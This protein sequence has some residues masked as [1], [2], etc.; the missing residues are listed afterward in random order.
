MNPTPITSFICSAAS[1]RSPASRSE[2]S[3]GSMKWTCAPNVV[4]G[5]LAAAVRAVVEGLV[6]ASADVED[7]ADVE[8][9]AARDGHGRRGMDEQQRNVGE[10]EHPDEEEQRPHAQKLA[11]RREAGKH[12]PHSRSGCVVCLP[13]PVFVMPDLFAARSQM[14]VS[15]AFHIIF[16][17][18]GIGLPALMVIAEYRWRRTG[19]AVYLELAKRWSKG[20]AILFAVGAV[21]G[22]VL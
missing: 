3:P 6:A 9:V 19:D 14:G 16:A 1:R 18:V 22:T 5:A 7:D 12:A 11:R 21:S 8:S 2:P 4:L 17:V 15:L 20:A 10:E 13:L